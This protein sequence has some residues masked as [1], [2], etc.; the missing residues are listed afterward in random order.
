MLALQD[1]GRK[2]DLESLIQIILKERTLRVF[3]D[4]RS[5]T[6]APGQSFL[7]KKIYRYKYSI[8]ARKQL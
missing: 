5:N 8:L 1:T 6:I 7:V 2:S 4:H 3:L